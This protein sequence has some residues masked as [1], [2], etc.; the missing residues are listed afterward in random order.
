MFGIKY[1]KFD[2]SNYVLHYKNGKIKQEGRGLSFFYFAPSSSIMAV[3]VG[4]NDVQFIF[5]EITNDFQRI[6]LQ[7]QITYKI[8]NPKQLTEY[9]DFTVDAKGKYKKNDL[10][11]LNQRLI[12]EAQATTTALAQSFNLKQALT[13][14]KAIEN[15]IQE[16]MINSRVVEMLGLQILSVNVIEVRPT[17]EMSKALEAQTREALQQE[18]D[19]AIYERRNFAVEQERKIKESELNTKIAVEEKK[20]HI[21]EKEMETLVTRKNNERELQ[22]MTIKTNIEIERHRQELIDLKVENERKE[23][24]TKKYVLES[25]LKPYKELD[26]KTLMAINSDGASADL[27]IAVA[28]RELAQNAE[29]IGTLNITPDLLQQLSNE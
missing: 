20:R 24:D 22:E 6:T 5:K 10:Q 29:K 27:N 11:K 18:S 28:F 21:V 8:E 16:G 25:T 13:S 4:S 19:L 9:L 17:P 12:N 15:K 2:A 1:I 26:W 7:G 3:P 14:V 23:A